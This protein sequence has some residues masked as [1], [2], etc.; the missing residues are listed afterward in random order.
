MNLPNLLKCEKLL[1][2][3][4]DKFFSPLSV[5]IEFINDINEFCVTP[6]VVEIFV[7]ILEVFMN[8]W[9]GLHILFFYF[10]LNFTENFCAIRSIQI[11]FIFLFLVLLLEQ[12]APFILSGN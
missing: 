6:N 10:I 3:Q 2:Y 4:Q 5:Q 11:A 12:K 9:T 8:S 7:H 1:N